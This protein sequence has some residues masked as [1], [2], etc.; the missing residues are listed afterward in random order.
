[1]SSESQKANL[2]PDSM[3]QPAEKTNC[4]L[5][6]E[7]NHHEKINQDENNSPELAKD[8]IPSSEWDCAV[9]Q[10]K[11]NSKAQLENH[12]FS[13]KHQR[14]TQVILGKGDITK[15]GLETVGELPP[16]WLD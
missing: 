4:E 12:C 7:S 1:M 6:L 5:V 16:G 3:A 2:N 9:C 11:C 8:Q 15:T 10:A 14:K 13:R